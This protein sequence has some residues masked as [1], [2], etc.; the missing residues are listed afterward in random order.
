VTSRARLE[1]S[2]ATFAR[3]A[4]GSLDVA[5]TLLREMINNPKTPSWRVLEGC[6]QLAE[7]LLEDFRLSKDPLVKKSALEET[8]KLL[9]KPVDVLPTCL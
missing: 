4:L 5:T 6:N 8:L 3:Q 1:S 7:I 9:D 2:A